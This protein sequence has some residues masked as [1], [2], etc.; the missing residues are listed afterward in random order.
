MPIQPM[1]GNDANGRTAEITTS[2]EDV[3][4]VSANEKG[5]PEGRPRCWEPGRLWVAARSANATG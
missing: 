3:R 1:A 5:R 4:P 2:R